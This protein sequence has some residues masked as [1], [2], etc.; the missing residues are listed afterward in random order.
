MVTMQSFSAADHRGSVALERVNA[1]VTLDAQHAWQGFSVTARDGVGQG[2]G[3]LRIEGKRLRLEGTAENGT[4]VYRGEASRIMA[5]AVDDAG[6]PIDIQLPEAVLTIRQEQERTLTTLALPGKSRIQWGDF[7]FALDNGEGNQATM[8]STPDGQ[9][10]DFTLRFPSP[11]EITNATDGKSAAIK[12]ARLEDVQAIFKNDHGNAYLALQSKAGV[13]TGTGNKVVFTGL[14]GEA[15]NSHAFIRMQEL[16]GSW[17]SEFTR[18]VEQQFGGKLFGLQ[19]QLDDTRLTADLKAQELWA[20]GKLAFVMQ[21][22][23]GAFAEVRFDKTDEK[24]WGTLHA[25]GNLSVTRPNGD[26]VQLDNGS[27]LAITTQQRGLEI[28]GTDIAL[29]TK[30]RGFAGSANI[31]SGQVALGDGPIVIKDI[32]NAS[33]RFTNK[34]GHWTGD[35]SVDQLKDAMLAYGFGDITKGQDSYL[36]LLPKENGKSIRFTGTFHLKTSAGRVRLKFNDVDSLEALL[37]QPGKNR[38]VALVRAP[39]AQGWAEV[40]LGGLVSVR[41]NSIVIEGSYEPFS[42]YGAVDTALRRF[43]LDEIY[44]SQAVVLSPDAR[45]LQVQTPQGFPVLG[46]LRV[47]F[48]GE[49]PVFRIPGASRPFEQGPLAPAI[50]L[51][52]GGRFAR[53]EVALTAGIDPASQTSFHVSHGQVL[54][55]GLPIGVRGF[56]YPSSGRVGMEFSV[57]NAAGQKTVTGG[58]GVL[59]NVLG[60]Q[61]QNRKALFIEEMPVAYWGAANVAFGPCQ[62]GGAVTVEEQF[63]K[64]WAGIGGSCWY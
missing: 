4:Y 6:R 15:G 52:I 33:F 43:A 20:D 5:T 10:Q 60:V 37:R 39:S 41:G 38:L 44:V 22:D 32:R 9:V 56:D 8:T 1:Q 18:G 23:N 25:R 46:A 36:A 19:V 42:G 12:S 14:A 47:L 34:R 58:V 21:G 26:R 13:L 62:M 40:K 3:G 35:V 48:G 28:T 24:Y 7:T 49:N 2:P 31:Q 27:K 30:L 53:T 59:A 57:A 54:A 50:D 16:Q 17:T 51:L 63:N 61:R 45:R 55:L 64:W 29:H 11:V